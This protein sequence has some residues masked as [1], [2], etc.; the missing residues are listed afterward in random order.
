MT[1]SQLAVV[2]DEAYQLL[3]DGT[4]KQYTPTNKPTPWK[5]IITSNPSNEQIAANSPD[6]LGI[7]Q[8]N[9]TVYRLTKTVQA[10]GSNASLLWAH[11]GAFWQWQKTTSKLWYMG[12][13]TGGKW[14][15]RDTDPH[16][17]DLAFVNDVTYQ[18]VVN[19]QIARYEAPGHWRIVESSYSNTAIA[20]DGGALYALKRDGQVARYDEGN[21]ELIG[22][23]TALQIA[24]GKAGLFQRQASGYIY[25][26]GGGASW[27]LVD[28]NA[29]N[30]NIA[31]AN[32]AYRVNSPGEI[33]I[34]RDNGSWE[35]IKEEDDHPAPPTDS[36]VHPEAVYDAGFKGTSPILLRIGNGGAGQTGLVQGE[37]VHSPHIYSVE[38]T[39]NDSMTSPRRS[40]HQI[41]RRIGF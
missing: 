7:R 9:G 41:A 40:I 39:T 23:A 25:K 12:K 13:E 28:Q 37:P 20:A 18:I 8:S 34:L 22:G 38:P 5:T 6:T 35:R 17:R 24:G 26:Y 11:A 10:I 19:G 1:L 4:I 15:V 16:T 3:T 33:Y 31:V 2:A 14:E 29:D 27:E 30:V 21:W 36:G 32:S